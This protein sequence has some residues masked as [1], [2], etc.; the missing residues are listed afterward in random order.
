MHKSMGSYIGLALTLVVLMAFSSCSTQ[1]NTWS[2]RTYHQMKVRY[3]IFY[4]G[5]IAYEEGLQ[6]IKT[7]H[8]DDYSA[9]LPLYPVS[10]HKAAESS[11]SQMDKTIEKCRKCIKLHSIKS[12]PKANPKKRND[13][14]YK[15]WLQQEEFNN[16][17]GNAWIR[18][19]EAEF[20][21]GDFLGAVGTFNY[22]ARH[23]ATDA[24][25]V[26]QCGLWT[27]RAYGE[28]GWLY[29]AEDALQKVQVDALSRKHAPLYSAVSADILLKTK[30]YHEAIPFVKIALPSE[31]RKLYRPRFQYVLA[32]LYER[33][34]NRSAASSAYKKVLRMTPPAEMDF[35][36]R[37]HRAQLEG[38]SAVKSLERLA[39]QAKYKDKLDQIYGAIGDIYLA[40]A[41]TAKALESY[42]T[43]IEKSTIPGLAK[44]A[45]LVK[46]GDLYF[47]RQD[48]PKA[49][50]LYR[51]ATSILSVESEDFARVQKRSE[52]LDELIVE[53]NAVQLQDSLQ[54]LSRM[55]EEEQLAVVNK[56]IE[57]LLK[58]EKEA[59]EKALIASREAEQ[60]GLASVDTR[61]MIGGSQSG[62]WYF[63]NPQLIKSGRQ[64]FARKW[65]SRTLE[66]NWRRLSKSVSAVFP[67]SGDEIDD[68]EQDTDSLAADSAKVKSTPAETDTHKPEYYLQQIPKTDADLAASDTIIATSLTNMVYIYQEKL[69]DQQLADETLAD[70]ARRFPSDSR[71]LDLYYMKYL[72]ALKQQDKVAEQNY[73]QLILS[74]FPA[75]KQAQI[76]ADPGYFDKL[77]VMAGEQDSLYEATYKAYTTGNFSEVK[78]NKQYAESAYPLSPLMPRFVFLNAVS[79]ARTEGQDAF[80]LEL[81]D[82]VTRYPESE[83]GAMAKDFLAMMGQ[84][85]ESQR[86][87]TSS[88]LADLRN[89]QNEE[90]VAKDADVQFSAERK[91][92]SLVLL[93]LPEGKTEDDLNAMLYQVA[94]FNFSQFL[95]RD[96]DLQKLPVFGNALALRISGL[97]S[98]DDA[99]WYQG[100]LEQNGDVM[101]EVAR[102]QAE[103]VLI[104]EE[105]SALL[106]THF[107][108][109]E[110]KEFMSAQKK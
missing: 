20:H 74:N 84:G 81:Q 41:D 43:A 22:V 58:A 102:Q 45:I 75:S 99:A 61:N 30:Q 71:L 63:Y 15:L 11:V 26:A 96:F 24:D 39:R 76:V 10:D 105:N 79:V 59:E 7:A 89:Q 86:G 48:Y 70:L 33:E 54:R 107:T 52:I 78:A 65:G 1:K 19:G 108:L 16:Q 69:E 13:P 46:A 73:R 17:M 8:E 62:D 83:L 6:S 49:Q 44:A 29:E 103:I 53:Y 109:N 91:T 36:A 50:P 85:M 94:L 28:L 68:I 60:Q 2:S 64:E 51:E 87:G 67:E 77:R 37:I 93:I 66:D 55:S 14:A 32:Q 34:G 5:N 35:N 9:I 106:N 27:A 98:M 18:L 95:I 40:A 3:N 88:S 25:V 23:Y 57:D 90:D 31:K 21:K 101:A 47:N 56:L 80:V 42:D 92:A 110:Y 38:K 100:M 4:N 97:D 104:T 72:E 12:K 82:M